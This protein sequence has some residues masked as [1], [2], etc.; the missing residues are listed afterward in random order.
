MM[1]RRFVSWMEEKVVLRKG[2]IIKT[3]PREGTD[4]THRNNWDE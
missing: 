2:E 4:N 1:A 3:K